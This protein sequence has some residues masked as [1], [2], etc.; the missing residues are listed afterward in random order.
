MIQLSTLGA[1]ELRRD[2]ADVRSV[3]SQPKRMALL[4]YLG[5]AAPGSFVSRDRLLAMFWPESDNERARNALRQSLHF[6]RRS[7]G[8]RVVVGRAEQE[9]G[10]APLVVECDAVLFREAVAAGRLEEALERYRGELLPGFHLDDVPEFARWLDEER[11]ALAHMAADAARQLVARD[12]SRGDLASATVWARRLVSLEPMSEAAARM[13][14]TLQAESGEPARALET[15]DDLAHRLASLEL[16]PSGETVA[17]AERIR[18]GRARPAGSEGGSTGPWRDGPA[19]AESEERP[20]RPA[21]VTAAPAGAAPSSPEVAGAGSGVR[22]GEAVS[23]RAVGRPARSVA[24]AGVLLAAAALVAPR[25]RPPP[26]AADLDPPS[27]AV[28]PF[29]DLSEGGDRRDGAGGSAGCGLA[30]R[31]RR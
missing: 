14:M 5:I 27:I 25:L 22:H 17:L 1:I 20:H 3:L 2:G 6:L 10:I 16:S 15:F 13:L 8:D 31:R 19:R 4:A 28:M 12:E 29:L 21:P 11:S 9:V 18:I 30:L 7:L 23:L 24:V 26:G